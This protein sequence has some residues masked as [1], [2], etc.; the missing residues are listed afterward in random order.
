MIRLTHRCLGLAAC[1]AL[2][3]ACGTPPTESA[4]NGDGDGS[5]S[6]SSTSDASGSE[7]G[8]ASMTG[9]G[10][11]DSGDGD[12]DGDGDSGDGDGDGDGGDGDGDGETGDGDTGDGDTG[13]GDTGDG[14]TGDTD[15]PASYYG[16]C[17][18]GNECL[19]DEYCFVD[20]NDDYQVCSQ[21][22]GNIGDCPEVPGQSLKCIGL[23]GNLIQKRCFISCENNAPCPMG[24]DCQ[25]ENLGIDSI[26]VYNQ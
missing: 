20:N 17:P 3:L 9:D 1:V 19:M 11:G 13:D 6:D 15:E 12:G 24:M 23:N 26:C 2:I 22:C 10:D 16:N 7:S 5:E 4:S 8:S 18:M 25:D 21:N 14:D